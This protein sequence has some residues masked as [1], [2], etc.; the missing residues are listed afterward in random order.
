MKKL[1]LEL[2]FITLDMKSHCFLMLLILLVLQ[3]KLQKKNL[4]AQQTY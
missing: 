4:Y 1:L 2:L 3:S